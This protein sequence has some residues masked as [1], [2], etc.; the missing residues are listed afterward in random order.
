MLFRIH[1]AILPSNQ[2]FGFL[3]AV[4]YRPISKREKQL[5]TSIEFGKVRFH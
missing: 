5:I 2:L 1:P 3:F 4:I